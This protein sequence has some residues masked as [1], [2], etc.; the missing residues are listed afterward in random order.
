MKP[1][2]LI[3][4][5][6]N[7]AQNPL[8]LK[9][10]F[11]DI[12]ILNQEYSCLLLHGGGAEVSR[13]SKVFGQEPCFRDGI[14]ITTEEE[15]DSVEMVLSGTMNKRLVRLAL[16][17]GLNA[18]GLSG[19]DN[20]T[21]V[22]EALG[23]GT[24]T[25]KVVSVNPDFL[26][27]LIEQLYFPVISPVSTDSSFHSLNIN[28][29]EA[30]LAVAAAL[31]ASILIFLSDIPGILKDSKVLSHLNDIQVEEEIQNGTIQGGMIPKVRSSISGL[32]QGIKQ[33]VIGQYLKKGDLTD[34]IKNQQG[35]SL[36]LLS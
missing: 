36:S 26:N 9:A 12:R 20:S 21:I 25:G 7:A 8:I 33:I 2:I 16:S 35:S 27:M 3:K 4:I 22:A 14:R 6:G 32:Q 19:S 30:A 34:L 5:G 13:V 1:V 23:S 29:D 11:E 18:V 24:R 31:K 15:M 10:L 17:A 28:A